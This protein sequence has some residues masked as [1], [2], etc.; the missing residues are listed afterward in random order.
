LR[1]YSFSPASEPKLT[2]PVD[3]QETTRGFKFGKAPGP[4]G[5]TNRALR[6]L[7]LRAI[8]LLVTLFNAILTIQY[9][10]AEWKHARV[11]SILKPGKDPALPSSYRP[12]SLLDTIGRLFEK[13]LLARILKEVSERGLLRDE[14]FGFRPKHSTSLHLAGLV[15]RVTRNYGEKRLTG[16]VFLDVAKAFDTVWVDGLVYRLTVLNF[17]SYLVRIITSYLSGRTFEASF[18]TAT[19]SRRGMRAGVDQGGIIS[20][21]LFSLYVYDMPI[22]SRHVRLALYADDTAVMAKSR[23]PELLVSYLESYLS[24]LERWLK[25]WRIAINVSKS[26]AMLFTRRRIHKPRPVQLFGEPILMGQCS[27][28]SGSDPRYTVNLVVSHRPG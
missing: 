6:H 22:P 4:D 16:A 2:N 18:Q 13:I 8:S 3:V 14:Q 1:A 27:P 7:P 28:L 21:V 15:E 25:E 11:F 5:I 17:P 26:T 12:I 24:D 23:K 19:S 10:P 20:P 9:F